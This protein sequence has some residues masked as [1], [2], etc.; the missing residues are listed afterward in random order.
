MQQDVARCVRQMSFAPAGASPFPFDFSHGL[1]RGL[2]SCAAIAAS[3]LSQWQGR[4]A[5]TT[6]TLIV[7]D[8][9]RHDMPCVK[10]LR[11]VRGSQGRLIDRP[12]LVMTNKV[13]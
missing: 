9:L 7:V 1:R 3:S 2:D 11:F 6:V 10:N 8:L 12:A 13:F 5:V 4:Q